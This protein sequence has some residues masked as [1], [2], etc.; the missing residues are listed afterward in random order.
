MVFRSF[1]I[2]RRS[3]MKL[4]DIF[5]N[6]TKSLF[7]IYN[8]SMKIWWN[9]LFLFKMNKHGLRIICYIIYSLMEK[10]VFFFT[11]TKSFILVI[12]NFTTKSDGTIWHY[13][14]LCLQWLNLVFWS[15]SISLCNLLEIFENFLK[16]NKIFSF[17]HVQ[18]FYI[19]WW[20]S[21]TVHFFD[22]ND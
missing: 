19:I 18:Y 5:F 6:I 15:F 9:Y 14:F 1:S 8:F 21:L 2:L 4:F 7:V 12:S 13:Y 3:L 16:L 10:Y 11:M 17:C 20:H 22:Y